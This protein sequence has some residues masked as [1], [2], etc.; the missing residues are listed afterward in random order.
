MSCHPSSADILLFATFLEDFSQIERHRSHFSR[1]LNIIYFSMSALYSNCTLIVTIKSVSTHIS[2]LSLSSSFSELS[3]RDLSC[4]M[5]SGKTRI[6]YHSYQRRH[7]FCN[8]GISQKSSYI[9][10]SRG[11][12]GHMW[13]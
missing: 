3:S 13:T 10:I 8:L 1:I 6:D 2:G 7:P 11:P 4:V 9:L 5:K 12:F